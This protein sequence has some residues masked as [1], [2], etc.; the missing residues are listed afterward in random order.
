MA[1]KYRAFKDEYIK[2][3]EEFCKL[4]GEIEFVNILNRLPLDKSNPNSKTRKAIYSL[5]INENKQ[6]PFYEKFKELKKSVSI[7]NF[8]KSVNFNAM[9]EFINELIAKN[10]IN[11]IKKI[12]AITDLTE[13]EAARFICFTFDAY[14]L[15]NPVVIWLSHET[16]SISYNH[17]YYDFENKSLKTNIDFKIS[18]KSNIEATQELFDNIKNPKPIKDKWT[19]EE[20]EEYTSRK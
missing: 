17:K 6:S 12:E 19:D 5:W 3:Y 2:D 9:V 7:E 1:I 20:L 8:F 11:D 13:K 18:G 14:D 16:K 15:L 10:H 4:A